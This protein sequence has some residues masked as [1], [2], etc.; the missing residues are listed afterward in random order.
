MGCLQISLGF[1]V[2]VQTSLLILVLPNRKLLAQAT[3]IVKKHFD[4]QL[5]IFLEKKKEEE[6]ERIK[7]EKIKKER[8]QEK[9]KAG[10]QKGAR[11]EEITE[12]EAKRITE[13]NKP[14]ETQ[15][16]E[17]KTESKMEDS[18]APKSDDDSGPAPIG[19][20]GKT[21]KYVWTQTLSEVV[22]N[23]PVPSSTRGKMV[24]VV[25]GQKK[26]KVGIKGQSP[27]IDGEFPER[28]KVFFRQTLA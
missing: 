15:Q 26:I 9:R 10:E 5:N 16:A 11:V 19:N 2:G 13:K 23:I 21:D 25:F 17:S 18:A 20:G 24:E 12:E 1:Y 22:I 3:S 7:S 8:E 28:I 4:Q 27:I 14:I 6:E